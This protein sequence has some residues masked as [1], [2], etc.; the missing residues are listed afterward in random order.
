MISGSEAAFRELAISGATLGE[1]KVRDSDVRVAAGPVL[2]GLDMKG[3]RHLLIPITGSDA[4][5]E[6]RNSTGVQIQVRSLIED[7]AT[8]RFLDVVCL[9]PD[10]NQLYSTVVDEMLLE[11]HERPGSADAACHDVLERWRELLESGRQKLL[12]IERQVALLAELEWVTLI[13]NHNAETAVTSWRGPLMGR[14]D[15]VSGSTALEV[16]ATL[17]REG[18]FAEIHGDRQL[19]PPDGGILYLSFHRY[20][21]VP[22]GG[23]SIPDQIDLALA[24]GIDRQRLLTLVAQAGYDTR[25]SEAYRTFRFSRTEFRVYQVDALFPKLIPASFAA[26]VTP[27]RVGEV[28]YVIDLEG[29]PPAPIGEP[30]I[31]A[32]LESLGRG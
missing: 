29:E 22:V 20:E 3:S 1:I 13:G 31:E 32:L 15:F 8:R 28:R 4:P 26:G 12:L 21:R 6:D 25:D 16:K 27:E 7:G 17:A 11:I 19:E 30:A 9:K 18:R 10:L 23:K 5:V 2:H 24:S 14:Q